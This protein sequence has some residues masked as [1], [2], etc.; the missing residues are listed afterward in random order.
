MTAAEEAR[1]GPQISRMSQ[2]KKEEDDEKSVL[3]LRLI[4]EICVICGSA[5]LS[6]VVAEGCLVGSGIN[7]S[8]RIVHSA[9]EKPGIPK[10]AGLQCFSDLQGH[11]VTG[12]RPDADY[13]RCRILA[14]IFR[15]F[16][17]IFRRPLPVFL[18][19]ISPALPSSVFPYEM[20]RDTFASG[21]G[22]IAAAGETIKER[23]A[24]SRTSAGPAGN[25]RSGGIVRRL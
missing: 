20:P 22:R 8:R 18:T 10:N 9:D 16:R 13:L 3:G 24:A 23:P 7:E 17:P 11:C 4:C 1:D 14:R 25:L 12:V 6:L 21:V 2:M 5:S 19:P 15:F